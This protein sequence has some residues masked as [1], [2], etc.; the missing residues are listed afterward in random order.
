MT[1]FFKKI[2]MVFI[3]LTAGAAAWAVIEILLSYSETIGN[4]LLW[5][6]LSGGSIGLLFGFFF[7]SAEGILFSDISRSVRGGITGALWGFAGGACALLFV[8]WLLY[9]LGNT[10]IFTSAATDSIIIPASRAFGWALL[11]LIIGSLDGIRSMSIRRAV[12]GG[13]GGF[14]GG[15]LGGIVLESLVRLWSNSLAARGAGIMILGVCIGLSLTLFEYFRSYGRIKI[16]TGMYRGKEYV[17]VMRKTRIG[18]SSRAH[19]PLSNYSGVE[20]YHAVLS[21]GRGGV[22]IQ[23]LNGTVIVNDRKEEKHDLKYEDVIQLGDAKLLYLP[24]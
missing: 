18:A 17:L 21:A 11:G 15:V 22:S 5:N 16:L 3:G 4:Y 14:V 2:F 19:I 7:G 24:K 6:I 8:Q 13:L 10:E 23:P 1:T 20:K 9:Q 12:I